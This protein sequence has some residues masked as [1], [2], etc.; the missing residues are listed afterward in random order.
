MFSLAET[1]VEVPLGGKKPIT[2]ADYGGVRFE[3]AAL[4]DNLL[5]NPG[6][7]DGLNGWYVEFGKPLIDETGGPD[8]KRCLPGSHSPAR[9][10]R[11]ET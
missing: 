9:R 11:Q 6:F 7:Q 1:G 3:D 5:T 10:R 4:P 2:D 8:G